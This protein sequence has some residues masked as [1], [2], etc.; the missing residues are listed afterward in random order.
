MRNFEE[1]AVMEA[2]L[3]KPLA[4]KAARR[5][6]F[7]AVSAEITK[8]DPIVRE[9][10]SAEQVIFPRNED[11]DG[12]RSLR[13]TV[14]GQFGSSSAEVQDDHQK[15]LKKAKKLSSLER[16]ITEQLVLNEENVELD[17]RVGLFVSFSK[18]MSNS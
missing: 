2:P 9:L 7:E 16:E 6:N 17:A 8:Y 5:V 13:L 18:I 12:G 15:P 4:Q 1:K 14:A 10:R 11:G 3:K